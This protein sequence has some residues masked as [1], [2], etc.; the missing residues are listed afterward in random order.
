MGRRV[1]DPDLAV[2]HERAEL[3]ASFLVERA[4][5]EPSV[6][7]ARLGELIDKWLRLTTHWRQVSSAHRSTL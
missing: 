5:I 3:V 2:D 1:R 4:V 6:L 7:G